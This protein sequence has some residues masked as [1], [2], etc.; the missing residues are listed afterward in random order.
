MTPRSARALALAAL[1]EWRG[2]REFADAILHR[3]LE[4]TPLATA[5]RAFATE[6]FYGVLRKLTLLD[7]WVSTLRTK[8]TDLETLDL[9]RLGLYQLF[10]LDTS[11]HAAVYETVAL[12]GARRRSIVNAILRSAVRRKAELLGRAE[13][14]P[15]SVRFSHPQF[16]LDRWL[17][18]FSNEQVADLCQWNN[19]PP[20]VYARI[21]QLKISVPQFLEKYRDSV[22]LPHA[23]GFVS[24]GNPAEPVRAGECYIQD[25]STTA[26][27]DL[28]DPQPD[29]TILDA[30]AAP[31]GKT[32]YIA[33]RMRNSGA[34]FATDRNADRVIQLSQN[35]DRLGVTNV[36]TAQID[37]TKMNGDTENLPDKF[38]RILID[39]PC[40]NTGVM[41]R[42]VDVRWRLTP[43]DFTRM[44]HEQLAIVR[45]VLPRLKS[46]G[47]LVYST[48]SLEREE[49][50]DVI[51][52]VL[53]EFPFLKLTDQRTVLPFV[54]R[55]DGAF[56][57][58]LERT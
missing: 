54:D 15:L 19:T 27:C 25:P 28:L 50:G 33:Q 40:S 2:G 11:E 57:A 51:D 26:A 1:G 6:L 4:R 37:W 21:N 46:G 32:A 39:A 13:V 14:Q 24:L 5:D 58:R 48:C 38:D 42:R 20:P 41:R 29:E 9:V 17:L 10:F 49:N 53:L 18:R 43:R 36:H 34:I 16:L 30:C 45:A 56:A 22:P 8:S 31:G 52:A 7:F 12:A 35:I 55:F 47:V 23:D 3:F 44:Q